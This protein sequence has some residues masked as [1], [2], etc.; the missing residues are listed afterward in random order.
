MG[1]IKRREC[2]R[3]TI[4]AM[5][6]NA[7]NVGSGV[8]RRKPPKPV[9]IKVAE[10]VVPLEMAGDW[11]D[12]PD[13]ANQLQEP[14]AYK[15]GKVEAMILDLSLVADLTR[16]NEILSNQASPK[17]NIV[18]VEKDIKFIEKTGSWK[19]LMTIQHVQF[20]KIFKKGLK[21]DALEAQDAQFN[22]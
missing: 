5:P 9:K 21:P 4:E 3:F 18:I 8:T 10:N 20:R 13:V 2:G 12:V 11:A 15:L 6:A 14:G 1:M 7:D 17:A 19:V 22:L 16:Y